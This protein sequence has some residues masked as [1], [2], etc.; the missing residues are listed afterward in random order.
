MEHLKAF[1]KLNTKI[2]F[3]EKICLFFIKPKFM[4]G[5]PGYLDLKYKEFNN[6]IYILK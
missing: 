2:S 5:E 3:F 6:K 4:K 1:G